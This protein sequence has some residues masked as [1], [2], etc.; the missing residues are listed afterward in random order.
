MDK[1]DTSSLLVPK[2]KKSYSK[3]KENQ[4]WSE[5]VKRTDSASKKKK[6]N[7]LS[8]RWRV[9][10]CDSSLGVWWMSRQGELAQDM[11]ALWPAHC[12][13]AAVALHWRFSPVCALCC[14][15]P[16]HYRSQG[17]SAVSLRIHDNSRTHRS[18]RSL[19]VLGYALYFCSEK[20]R[21]TL[22]FYCFLKIHAWKFM[23]VQICLWNLWKSP[24]DHE[25]LT[26]ESW[27]RFM[28]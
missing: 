20:M 7:T 2:N 1:V 11:G 14:H 28:F 21:C 23:N 16:K 17:G 25:K 9:A 15:L 12:S 6:S 22:D 26:P 8:G 3:V 4:N 27:V 5:R 18:W 10:K 19:G 13:R 24:F